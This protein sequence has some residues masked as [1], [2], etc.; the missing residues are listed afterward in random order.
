MEFSD[1]VDYLHDVLHNLNIRDDFWELYYEKIQVVGKFIQFF[2][3]LLHSY[4][5]IHI[6]AKLKGI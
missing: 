4:T 5:C 6:Y 2:A 3:L 1:A